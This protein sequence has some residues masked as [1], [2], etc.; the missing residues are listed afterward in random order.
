LSYASEI[1]G[2]T[3]KIEKRQTPPTKDR[4]ETEFKYINHKPTNVKAF[5]VG[6]Q[7][8]AFHYPE[9]NPLPQPERCRFSVRK[10]RQATEIVHLN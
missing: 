9:V 4:A 7:E 3:L 8:K 6:R 1:P 10:T 2:K 5:L